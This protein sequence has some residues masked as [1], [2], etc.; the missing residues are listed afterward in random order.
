VNGPVT[1]G[2][3]R[4]TWDLRDPGASL[5]TTRTR[6]PEDDDDGPPRGTGPLVAPG[7]YRASLFKRVNGKAEAMG[8]AVEFNVVLDT[9]GAPVAADVA[10]QV[11][12]H[13]QVL[14]LSRA[15]NG[16][17]SVATEVGTRL[18]Q[19]RRALDTAP[20]ADEPAKAKVRELIAAHRAVVRELR[21]DSV[22]RSRNESTP[23]S[24]SERVNYAGNASTRS[25]SKPTGTQK[26]Q[27]AIAD[28]AFAAELA[29]L[30][31]LVEVELPALEK[32]LDGFDAPW[33]PGRLPAWGIG[34]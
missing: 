15:V 19:I 17:S 12:F 29:K 32:R 25:L 26:D 11:A 9:L 23:S 30:K 1:E 34:K 3:H 24:I 7:K 31:Q 21:G 28:K 4:I 8:E 14:K 27:Y 2:T 10:E 22:M 18:E 6:D 20:K 13:R 16:A 33:T 5:P